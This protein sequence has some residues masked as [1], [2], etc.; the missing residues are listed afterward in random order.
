MIELISEFFQL[1]AALF[2]SIL[3]LPVSSGVTIGTYMISGFLI[4]TVSGLFLKFR[5]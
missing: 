3:G 5:R 4:L 2:S 1:S